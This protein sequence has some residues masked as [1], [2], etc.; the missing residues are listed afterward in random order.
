MQAKRM[1]IAGEIETEAELQHVNK[2]TLCV[3]RGQENPETLLRRKREDQMAH[4]I[5]NLLASSTTQARIQRE[6]QQAH[7]AAGALERSN[8]NQVAFTYDSATAPT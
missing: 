1:R 4:V 6:N 3:V 7:A 8:P 2:A 5:A